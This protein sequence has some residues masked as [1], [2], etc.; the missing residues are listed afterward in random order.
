MTFSNR[1]DRL[2]LNILLRLAYTDLLGIPDDEA[3][4]ALFD[5]L[6]FAIFGE[7][8]TRGRSDDYHFSLSRAGI[9][10]AQASIK[11]VLESL[12]TNHPAPISVGEHTVYFV[13]TESGTITRYRCKDIQTYITMAMTD[14]LR[15]VTVKDLYIC[16][17]Q[18]CRTVFV[19]RRKPHNGVSPYCC[20]RHENRNTQRKLRHERKNTFRSGS[21][22]EVGG[23]TC[24]R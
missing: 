17:D 4:E 7:N 8:R 22:K 3:W 20:P 10:L 2:R 13:P 5:E 16:S 18:E 15:S 21:A 6:H 19:P 14:L 23:A 24:A 1:N 11:A 9:G 12:R